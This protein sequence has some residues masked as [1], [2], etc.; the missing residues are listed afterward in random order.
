MD[1]LAAGQASWG[2]PWPCLYEFVRVV[3]HPGV[4]R[5]PTP[6]EEAVDVIR[7]LL[8]APAVHPLAE[9]ERHADML[10]QVA[11]ETPPVGNLAHDL[12]IAVLLRE[13]GV[14]E[15]LTN[16]SDFHKFKG[17]KVVNPFKS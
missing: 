13:H 8:S 15:L 2:L 17:F 14:T 5:T 11:R 4:F 12:H 10:A 7:L 16:D 9:T 6:A 1:G 3:T